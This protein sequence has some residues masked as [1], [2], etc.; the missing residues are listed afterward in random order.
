MK[1]RSFKLGKFRL[2][3]FEKRTLHSGKGYKMGCGHDF[4]GT[5]IVIYWDGIDK[6]KQIVK[7]QH[8]REFK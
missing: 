4:I 2:G 7:L 1:W 6:F 5:Y 8:D 3:W